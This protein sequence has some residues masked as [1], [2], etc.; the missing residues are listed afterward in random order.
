MLLDCLI[1]AQK[2]VDHATF[3]DLGKTYLAVGDLIDLKMP[4]SEVCC[5]MRIADTVMTVEVVQ[6][7]GGYPMAQ[8]WKDGRKF[9]FPILTSEAGIYTDGSGR[10]YAYPN[11]G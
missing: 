11:G 9:S 7:H 2:A 4:Y 8:L 5:H 10:M 1:T 3:G 6:S